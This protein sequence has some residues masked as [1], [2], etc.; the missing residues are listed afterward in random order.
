MTYLT[1][2]PHYGLASFPPAP[3]EVGAGGGCFL[4]F[5]LNMGKVSLL[6]TNIVISQHDNYML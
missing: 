6:T 3:L 2:V 1:S 5:E 4:V